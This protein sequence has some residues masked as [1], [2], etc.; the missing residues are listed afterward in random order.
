[1]P[2]VHEE[3]ED[4]TK[5]EWGAGLTKLLERQIPAFVFF[6]LGW[7]LLGLPCYLLTGAEPRRK[8]AHVECRGHQ[9]K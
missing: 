2:P 5:V 1:M 6:L 7:S 9:H 4:L 3:E 8:P